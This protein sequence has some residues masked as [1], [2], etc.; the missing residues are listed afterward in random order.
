MWAPRSEGVMYPMSQI[1]PE[2]KYLPNYV[3][4]DYV[5]PLNKDDI[6]VWRGKKEG[7][8]LKEIKHREMPSRQLGKGNIQG[9]NLK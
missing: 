5:R 8:E 1:P 4:F 3:W 2:K 6:F 9:L 7:T